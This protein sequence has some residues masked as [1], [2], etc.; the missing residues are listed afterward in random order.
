[1]TTNWAGSFTFTADRVESPTSVDDLRRLV[2]SGTRAHVLGAGHS[3]SRVADTTGTLIRLDALPE[4]FEL[5]GDTVR[6]GGGTRLAGLAERLHAKGVALP[7]MPSLPHV[8]IA[9]AVAT[10]TH[11]SGDGVGTLAD[12]VRSVDLVTAAGDLVTYRRGDA[13]FDGVVVSLGALG[14]VVALELAV[15]P[16]FD[17]E[18]RVVADVP[19]DVLVERF[20]DVFSAAYSV[21]AFTTWDGTA[22]IWVKRRTGDA[23]ADLSFTGGHDATTPLH[24]V[25]GQPA[26][27]CTAQLGE[28]GP[29]HERLPH[30]RA[31]FTP[32]V[33][34]ELQSE[35]FVA[36]EHASHALTAID[37]LRLGDLLLTS[38]IRTIAADRQWL[39]PTHERDS[40][41]LHFTWRQDDAAVRA[42]LARIEAALAPWRPRAHWGKLSTHPGAYPG[43]P[44]FARLRE[45]L[46]PT[47]TFGNAALDAWLSPR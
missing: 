7:A 8:T 40:V 44:R 15:V 1:M 33:G 34:R 19:L 36:R 18:Q 24:P 42:E 3:F 5:T 20:D 32:S 23:P 27:H 21:S 12:L 37:D 29:W 22:R 26:H 6:V 43:L 11:G 2:S 9:G 30:F 14:V 28:P 41:A 25:P 13:D 35:Y 17:V 45:S 46:D 31:D 47:G 4:V 39:S 10:G 16:T 38:E